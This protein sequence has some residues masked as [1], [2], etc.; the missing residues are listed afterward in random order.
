M[1]HLLSSKRAAAHASWDHHAQRDWQC[2]DPQPH[3]APRA[4]SIPAEPAGDSGGMGCSAESPASGRHGAFPGPGARAFAAVPRES[5]PTSR[6]KI[7]TIIKLPRL[8]ALGLIRVYQLLISPALPSA[9][10]FYPT[11]SEYARLAIDEWGMAR[12]SWLALRRLARCH[13]W[14]GS[15]WDPAP[16]KQSGSAPLF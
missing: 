16:R 5:A 4:G 11:C 3:S 8:L 10:R 1:H 13:P 7:R 9:C 2:C 14:G 12:G 15:G 6:S